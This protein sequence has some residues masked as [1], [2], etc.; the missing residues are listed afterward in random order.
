[1]TCLKTFLACEPPRGASLQLPWHFPPEGTLSL[2]FLFLPG[3]FTECMAC[4]SPVGPVG[5]GESKV[6]FLVESSLV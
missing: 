4:A 5:K 3:K 1:M 2:P 6:L